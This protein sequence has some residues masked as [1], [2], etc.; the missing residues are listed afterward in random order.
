METGNLNTFTLNCGI[1]VIH[2]QINSPISHCG[3][4]INTGTR[5]ELPY[6]WGMAHFVEHSLFKGTYKRKVYHI[7]NR[8]DNVGGEL[9]AFTTKEDTNLHA[10]F[11][12]EYYDRATELLF[13]ICFHST[14]PYKEIEKE[15]AIILD[16]INSYKDSPYDV[17]F[18]EIEQIIF[19]GH[20]MANNILG[21]EQSVKSFTQRDLFDFVE[22]TYNTDQI[23]FSSISKLSVQK[24]KKI[25]G[26]Y[27]ERIKQNLRNYRRE[28]ILKYR[29][30]YKVKREDTFQTHVILGSRAYNIHHPKLPI[31]ILLNNLLGGPAMNSKLNLNIREKYGY[32]YNIESFY[33]P[34]TDT[35]IV[36]IYLGTD[37]GNLNKSLKLVYK[38]L[39]KIKNQKLTTVQLNNA[40][41]QLIA[42]MVMS[43]D[44]NSNNM[45]IMGKSLLTFG[46][47]ETLEQSVEKIEKITGND[48]LEVANQIYEKDS[49]STLI[50][51]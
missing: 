39:D 41:K 21:S 23:V 26:K 27:V 38:E 37:K 11:L 29:P 32:A 7:L 10:S 30:I 50:Y 5:D 14:F 15:K 49:I 35:G 45:L 47:I 18:D 40:K 9:N 19:Q 25:I 36:G 51:Q 20:P 4:I 22:R 42:Q 28:P 13:D 43:R 24:V 2:Q 6:Q 48:I 33:T 8:L 12:T 34:Y 44:Q 16:E 1:R 31:L 46:E 3:I 17:I